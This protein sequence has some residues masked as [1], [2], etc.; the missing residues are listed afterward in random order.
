M[1][2]YLFSKKCFL[3]TGPLINLVI[4]SF[5]INSKAKLKEL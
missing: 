4:F 1:P 5:L 3:D 2:K